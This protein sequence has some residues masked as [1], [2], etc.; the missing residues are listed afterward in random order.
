MRK[1]TPHAVLT[2]DNTA[3]AMA[4]QTAA[5][6]GKVPGR[7]IPVPSEVSAGCGLAWSVPLKGKE[8]LLSA[9]QDNNLV[10]AAL[11]V[12]DLY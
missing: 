2:F 6:A 8:T 3:D 12:V 9:L 10:F 4:V 7:V 1:K 5:D 11:F